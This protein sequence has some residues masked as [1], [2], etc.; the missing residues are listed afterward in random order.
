MCHLQTHPNS[1]WG[2]AFEGK[3]E[4]SLALKKIPHNAYPSVELQL[5]PDS[6]KNFQEISANWLH[7]G[8]RGGMLTQQL[9]GAISL[10]ILRPEIKRSILCWA[11]FF[12]L[13]EK[14]PPDPLQMGLLNRYLS[15]R[16]YNRS[17]QS[18]SLLKNLTLIIKKIQ[19][20]SLTKVVSLSNLG[21]TYE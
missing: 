1:T 14:V 12:P 4:P 3:G 6:Q 13:K 8:G 17:N 20:G 7:G 2:S 19:N 18:N 10:N 9:S 16:T 11:A 21:L 5:P 15:S